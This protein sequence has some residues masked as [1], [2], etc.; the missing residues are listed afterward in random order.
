[1]TGLE[2]K[3]AKAYLYGG[4]DLA[5][6]S[7]K[8][9]IPAQAVLHAVAVYLQHRRRQVPCRECPWRQ[10]G[11]PCVLPRCFSNVEEPRRRRGR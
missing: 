3:A 8:W 5:K 10:G 1:M 4:K 9:S 2:V 6:V 11:R 7:Y